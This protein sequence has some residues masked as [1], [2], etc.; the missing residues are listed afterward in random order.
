MAYGCLRLA[1]AVAIVAESDAGN[2]YTWFLAK[3][4]LGGWILVMAI[5][6][7]IPEMLSLLAGYGLRMKTGRI[8]R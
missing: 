7:C 6:R 4:M 8:A 3:R 2:T 1:A 5:P